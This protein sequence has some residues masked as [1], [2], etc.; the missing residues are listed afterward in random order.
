MNNGNH[1][2]PIW[3][4]YL[5]HL[6]RSPHVSSPAI[7][8]FLLKH[9]E[10][11]TSHQLNTSKTSR[12]PAK[13]FTF[14]QALLEVILTLQPFQNCFY[15]ITGLCSS[16]P[17]QM[18]QSQTIPF[19]VRAIAVNEI[20]H[21]GNGLARQYSPCILLNPSSESV[22]ATNLSRSGG[23]PAEREHKEEILKEGTLWQF[24]FSSAAWYEHTRLIF[25]S[26][27]HGDEEICYRLFA[28]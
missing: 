6:T 18:Y 9:H 20:R 4:W 1:K 14:S 19:C 7:G 11:V 3:L 25:F 27:L 23:Y 26:C 24:C 8:K 28:G 13:H 16:Y 10:N 21:Q 22:R 12:R 15:L 2:V 5:L 17:R